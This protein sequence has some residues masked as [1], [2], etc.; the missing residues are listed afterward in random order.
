MAVPGAIPATTDA[1][2]AALRAT[3]VAVPGVI[4]GTTD[5]DPVVPRATA[6]AVPGAIP[7]TTDAAPA[8]PRATAVAGHDVIPATK[9]EDTPALSAMVVVGR[10]VRGTEEVTHG[11]VTERIVRSAPPLSK[12][13]AVLSTA[14]SRIRGWGE[15]KARTIGVA[16]ARFAKT[17]ARFV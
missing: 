12:A 13:A 16:A 17:K 14:S 11:L 3:A 7:A 6:V 4:P 15:T 2:P 5:A 10:V 9:G 8:G 1:D